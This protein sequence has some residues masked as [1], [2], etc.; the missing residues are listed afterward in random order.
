M[1]GRK[2]SRLGGRLIAF[3]ALAAAPSCQGEYPIAP[4]L[5]DEWCHAAQTDDC[6]FGGPASCVA[7]CEREGLTRADCRQ[8][9][10]EALACYRGTP[11]E[12]LCFP[13]FPCSEQ[14][15]ALRLCVSDPACAAWCEATQGLGCGATETLF[16]VGTC[17]GTLLRSNCRSQFDEALA[18]YRQHTR[19][20]LCEA[21][22]SAS[23]LP[24]EEQMQA[25]RL[26]IR[27]GADVC[28]ETPPCDGVE[29]PGLVAWY[30]FEGLGVRVQDRAGCDHT[31]DA[32]GVTPC[33]PGAVGQ[34]FE[35][36]QDAFVSIPDSP[37]FA[38]LGQLTV[39]A[40]VLHGGISGSGRVISHGDLVGGDSFGVDVFHDG[41]GLS[42][43][44]P[45]D[46]NTP[47]CAG[48]TTLRAFSSPLASGWHHVA[49][50]V[51]HAALTAHFYLDGIRIGSQ[52]IPNGALCPTH[53]PLFIGESF[54]GSIDELKLWN[55][56]RGDEEICV[57]A[58][59]SFQNGVC[60]R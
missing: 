50:T 20:E 53:E 32:R 51:D 15:G 17:Q 43:G 36:G 21:W 22:S 18:C 2:G 11:R 19:Q 49:V 31:G 23:G 52:A 42:L 37:A 9:F 34:A 29:V 56:V 10:D 16:C 58:Q 6:G 26:C 44:G 28:G 45:Y 41:L 12:E 38:G 1:R 8:Q 5:C 25:L 60:L 3:G 57:A 4:T 55:V 48:M 46:P 47:S 33:R 27:P 39:E 35:F 54:A 30:S 59:G 14:E 13:H 24:C 40:R 7:A